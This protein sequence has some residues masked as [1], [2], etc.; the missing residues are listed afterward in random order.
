MPR[1]NKR[2]H[3]GIAMATEPPQAVGSLRRARLRDA[4]ALVG[5]SVV[6]GALLVAARWWFG[7]SRVAFALVVDR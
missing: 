7:T 6:I 2:A 3:L 4:V 5:T 1:A